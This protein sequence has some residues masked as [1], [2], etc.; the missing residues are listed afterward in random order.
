[1]ASEFTD[2]MFNSTNSHTISDIT[3][4]AQQALKFYKDREIV[5][6]MEIY[7]SDGLYKKGRSHN[8][9]PCS[10]IWNF[11]LFIRNPDGNI[12]HLHFNR[13]HNEQW[14]KVEEPYHLIPFTNYDLEILKNAII[15][16]QMAYAFE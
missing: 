9:G 14:D 8:K 16:K 4:K 13:E 1:M 15:D 5:F 7:M 10:H 11:Y 12:E 3:P 6:M 2:N